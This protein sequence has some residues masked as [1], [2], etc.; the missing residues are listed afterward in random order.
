MRNFSTLATIV[1]DTD[2][3][4]EFVGVCMKKRPCRNNGTCIDVTESSYRCNCLPWYTGRNCTVQFQPCYSSPCKNGGQCVNRYASSSAWFECVCKDGFTGKKCQ[5][6]FG[7]IIHIL[8]LTFF[9]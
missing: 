9:W 6:K 1:Y 8:S 5:T 3:P 7:K 2:C 4:Y